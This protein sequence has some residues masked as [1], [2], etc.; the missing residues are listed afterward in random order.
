VAFTVY[1]PSHDPWRWTV[2]GRPRTN[3]HWLET[4]THLTVRG[5]FDSPLVAPWLASVSF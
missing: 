2:D 3:R 4:T 1:G 5:P